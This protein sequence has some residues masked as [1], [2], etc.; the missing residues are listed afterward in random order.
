MVK[1]I[2]K[3]FWTFFAMILVVSMTMAA[4]VTMI[5]VASAHPDTYF[6]V[7]P[8]EA[9]ESPPGYVLINIKIVDA[10]PSAAWEIGLSWDPAL[11]EVGA[12]PVERNFLSRDGAHLTILTNTPLGEANL[13]GEILIKCTLV[14][15]V[16]IDEWAS[17]DG[18]L[19]TVVFA[20]KA[21]AVG[22]TLLNLF[23]T[24]LA[25]HFDEEGYYEQTYYPNNDS[26][27]RNVDPPIHDIRVLGF[28]V[29]PPWWSIKMGA[30]PFYVAAG[31][32]VSV[33]VTVLN[34]GTETETF[35]FYVYADLNTTVIGDEITV[36]T[37]AS[38]SLNGTGNSEN[39][40]STYEVIWDTTGVAA[41]TYNIT[42]YA[43]PVAGELDTTDNTFI[44][45]TVK[46]IIHDV[47]VTS[48]TVSPTE[49]AVGGLVTVTVTVK[50]E[51]TETENF[52]VT[53]NANEI[54]IDNVTVSSLLPGASITDDI[55]WNTTQVPGETYT[56]TAY[57]EPVEGEVD[58]ADNTLSD[59]TVTVRWNHDLKITDVTV[60]T[61]AVLR[62]QLAKINVTV[63]N[64]G[65]TD[66]EDFNV[67]VYADTTLI[68]WLATNETLDAGEEKT[69]TFTWDTTGAAEGTYTIS[70][71]VPPVSGE[72][73]PNIADNTYDDGTVEIIIIHDV[74]VISVT[75][76]PTE[77][78][79]GESVNVNATVKN[80]GTE[81]E[82]FYVSAYYNESLIETQTVTNLA[83]GANITLTFSW[84]TTDVQWGLY[85]V[86][87]KATLDGDINLGNNEKIDGTV[88]LLSPPV[89]DFTY[90]SLVV[91]T[92]VNFTSTSYDP[93]GGWI[94]SWEWDLDGDG[95]FDFFT[96]NTN[97]TYTEAKDYNV[98][99]TVTDDD[100]LTG[101]KTVTLTVFPGV[102]HDVAITSVTTSPTEV[103]LGQKVTI[104]VVAKNK[105]SETETFNV[106]AYYDNTVI[107]VKKVTNLLSGS[108]KVLTFTWN[109]ISKGTYTIK[110]E[111]SVVPDEINT[112]DN[113]F[114]D[115]TVQVQGAT[116]DI[117]MDVGSIHFKGE[118][119]EFYILVSLL[120]EPTDAEIS[121]TLYKPDKTTEALTTQWIAAGFYRVPYTIP[122]DAQPGTYV[123]VVKAS[124]L[125]L[126]GASLKSFLLNP[127]LTGWN[128]LLIS[129][130]GTVGTIKTDVGLIK[131]KLDAVD[132]TLVSV[133]GNIATINSNIGL[134]QTDINTINAKLVAIN[135]TLVTIQTDVGLIQVY[136]ED[137]QLEVTEINGN[138]ATIETTLGII[139]G[140]ITS[141]EEDIATI[142]TDV[143]TVQADISKVKGAQESFTTP[144][145][146][147]IIPA[148]IAAIGA[149]LA[150]ILIR[151]KNKT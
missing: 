115:G 98:T 45:D 4:M 110:A 13:K 18:W 140:T 43:E 89:A 33:N 84:N 74:A 125:A 19:C 61:P 108:T 49:V 14:G 76:S 21:G 93:D 67:T 71:E 55:S 59:G 90:T 31:E 23:D 64:Q 11:L 139:E 82:T 52:N 143:G 15:E 118:I 42:A 81:T 148:L 137:I 72:V 48:V 69:L 96:E 102:I 9:V 112:D 46:I 122:T 124:Y 6:W 120:G 138:T 47:A 85:T 95:L 39:R 30:I 66:G 50:N 109:T 80:E 123:L 25:D 51:G 106:T 60:L 94:T 119:A 147:A 141:I 128:A 38:A 121:A 22:S 62:G 145:Y 28:K 87:A 103:I 146:I 79:V 99:L 37:I 32:P 97:Y 63:L 75:V 91:D 16:P 149:I 134:I 130:N 41:G 105:G 151:R 88:T 8:P 1:L 116:L 17:G 133:E 35:D 142:E 114:V 57:A 150:I 131:V 27:F 144:L 70:A 100:G 29:K 7:D 2:K 77:V 135:G 73:D 104:T 53:V 86:K 127:T 10:P 136:V 3:Q 107:E 20:V 44:A 126:K 24:N 83:P 26:F 78:A 117:A 65:T 54:V 101:T 12:S 132:A 34:E 40:T 36:D 58:T 68:G 129:L 92:Q 113:I 5:N 111:A 56:I